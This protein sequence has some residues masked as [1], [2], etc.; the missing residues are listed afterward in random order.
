[1]MRRLVV[2]VAVLSSLAGGV[3]GARAADTPGSALPLVRLV[4]CDTGGPD[5]SA[6]FYGRMD[7]LPGATRMAMRFVVLERLGRGADWTKVDVPALRAWHRSA[8]GIK[9]FVYKQTVDNLRPGG[10]YKARVTF[11]WTTPAGDLVDSEV[12]ETPVCH[13]PLPNLAIGSL[14]VRPG[15]TA[16]TRDYRVTI[17]NDGKADASQ[18]DVVLSV[19]HAILDKITID[20][21]TA[22]DS[23]AVTFTG[24]A[25]SKAVRVHLDPANTVGELDEADNSQLFA[26]P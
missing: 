5:R 24:P 10:S 12:R 26:C 7:A 13:G 25:C 2:T 17:A 9:T 11:R 15:P 1:M 3:V 21:L 16:D 6:V 23:H 22:G 8:P 18:V 19:D 14:D 4:S 20:Q